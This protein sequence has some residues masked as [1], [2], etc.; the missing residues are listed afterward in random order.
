MKTVEIYEPRANAWMQVRWCFLFET[1]YES[2]SYI[3][4]DAVD[5]L[6][7]IDAFVIMYE[8][9]AHGCCLLAMFR[10]IARYMEFIN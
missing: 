5:Y 1:L 6:V 9:G 8:G 4:I 2:H 10:N 7:M 3:A